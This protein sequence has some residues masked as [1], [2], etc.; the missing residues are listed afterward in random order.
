MD[1]PSGDTGNNA[2]AEHERE[3]RRD[4]ELEKRPQRGDDADDDGQ[5]RTVLAPRV[6]NVFDLFFDFFLGNI[7]NS[8][9]GHDAPP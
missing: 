6:F 1:A 7:R 3:R 5:A 2:E 8:R 9:L 4:P